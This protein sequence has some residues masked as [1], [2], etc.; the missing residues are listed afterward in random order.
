MGIRRHVRV[1]SFLSLSVAFLFVIREL[2]E[3]RS[4]ADDVSNDGEVIELVVCDASSDKA[5][6]RDHG[7]CAGHATVTPDVARLWT[8][9]F[10][11]IVPL[12]PGKSLLQWLSLRRV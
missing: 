6:E 7:E 8:C 12:R 5:S 9:R 11:R 1:L 10:S 4:L 2:P 3:L